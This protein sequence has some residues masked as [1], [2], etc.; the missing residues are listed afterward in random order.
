MAVTKATT[1]GRTL[2][3]SNHLKCIGKKVKIVVNTGVAALGK[4]GDYI[5]IK[6]IWSANATNAYFSFEHYDNFGQGICL[7]WST[8]ELV[9]DNL[10]DL[11]EYQK[12]IDSRKKELDEE[13][14]IAAAKIA[15]LAETGE[16]EVDD[17]TFKVYQ[18]IKILDKDATP[19][20]KAKTLTAIF[21][22]S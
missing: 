16:K 5:R 11:K 20:Q 13:Y 21:N 22:K 17:H 12:H 1:Q 4:V 7:N 19:L 10:E 2:S 6:N 8:F 3:Y 18:T 15:F 14:E 9:A